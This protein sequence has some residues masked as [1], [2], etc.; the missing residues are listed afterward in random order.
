MNPKVDQYIAKAKKWQKEM[1]LLRSLMLD[2][3][4]TEEL[5]W[6]VPCYTYQNKNILL[7]GAFKNYCTL[8]FFKGVLLNDAENILES[9]GE[10]SQSVKMMKF[11]NFKDITPHQARIKAYIF[12]AIEVEKAGLKVDLKQSTNLIFPEELISMLD[13][14]TALKAAF[15]S[16]TP[17]RQRGYNLHFSAPKQSQTR[18]S[19]IENCMERILSGK[20]INDCICGHTKRPPSCDG[21]HK[22]I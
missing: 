6:R 14:N 5:K 9:P 20:G 21:S 15:E 22:Y 16:L 3:G 7:I 2:C 8:S 10:N 4:L 18:I 19:R 12:E 1:E 11:T 17:G 13:Q